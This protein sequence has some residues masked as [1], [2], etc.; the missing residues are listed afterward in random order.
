MICCE[1]SGLSG[2]VKCRCSTYLT[3]KIMPIKVS[4]SFSKNQL[5]CEEKEKC[6]E[7]QLT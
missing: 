2:P 1:V 6:L 3:F 4:T 5:S 7:C